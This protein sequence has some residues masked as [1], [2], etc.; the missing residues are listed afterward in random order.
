[1]WMFGTVMVGER[2]VPYVRQRYFFDQRQSA[3][4]GSRMS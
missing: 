1:M 3:G 2:L 4:T